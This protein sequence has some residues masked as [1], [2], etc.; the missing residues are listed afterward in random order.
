MGGPQKLPKAK[1]KKSGWDLFAD[2]QYTYPISPEFPFPPLDI[3]F[4]IMF[5]FFFL[6]FA[7]TKWKDKYKV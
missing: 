5:L 6:F 2:V 1:P 3:W 7:Q 4:S